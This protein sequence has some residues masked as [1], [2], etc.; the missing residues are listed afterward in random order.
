[1]LDENLIHK[2]LFL[3]FMLLAIELKKWTEKVRKR[4]SLA[5]EDYLV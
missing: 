4:V 1:M 2:K 3:F 5:T